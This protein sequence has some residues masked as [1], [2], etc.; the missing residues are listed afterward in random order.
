LHPS[1]SN[2]TLCNFTTT[3]RNLLKSWRVSFYVTNKSC[4]M[5]T[6][7]CRRRGRSLDKI[8]QICSLRT[9]FFGDDLVPPLLFLRISAVQS[10]RSWFSIKHLNFAAILFIV[11]FFFC[12]GICQDPGSF[13]NG[14]VIGNDYSYNSSVR[15]QCNLDYDLLGATVLTCKKGRWNGTMPVC[16][17]K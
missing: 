6:Q 2:L 9:K 3:T 17:S 4:H 5:Q 13:Y 12:A 1:W 16:K 7:N 8:W 14:K 15:F 11:T 10:P